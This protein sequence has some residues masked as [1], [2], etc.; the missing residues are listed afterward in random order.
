MIELTITQIIYNAFSNNILQ[1]VL[2]VLTNLLPGLLIGYILIFTIWQK[3]IMIIA[4]YL[5]FWTLG[6]ALKEFL[7][8]F[9][10]RIR[11][12]D[13]LNIQ[14]NNL[15]ENSF[16]SMHTYIAFLS[17]FFIFYLTENK[18]LRI[19]A[20]IIAILTAFT[21]LTLAQ[22]YLSDILTG[23]LLALIF[24][25]ISKKIYKNFLERTNKNL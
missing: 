25:L 22:H 14:K 23:F 13:I 9:Y 18:Y 11:P 2:E 5:L 12:Y 15:T 20:I 17:A 21:R 10:F 7:G 19:G 1:K 8:G 6:F 24:W 3:K 4:L 16:Y